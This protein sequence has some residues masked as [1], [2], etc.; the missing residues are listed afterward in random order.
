MAYKNQNY[1]TN[2]K[3][4]ELVDKNQKG[5]VEENEPNTEE[6][7]NSNTNNNENTNQENNENPNTNQENNENPNPNQ[8]PQDSNEE[9]IDVQVKITDIDTLNQVG[10]GSFTCTI[11][12]KTETFTAS[13]DTFVAEIE[14]IS[15]GNKII[16]ISVDN[17]V[18]L[19]YDF[20]VATD[21]NILSITENDFVTDYGNEMT[22][23]MSTKFT[24]KICI[25][26]SDDSPVA[27]KGFKLENNSTGEKTDAFISDENGC[28]TIPNIDGGT[29][30]LR[31]ND[32]KSISISDGQI[33]ITYKRPNANIH[34]GNYPVEQSEL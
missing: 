25:K 9:L 23:I 18:D 31:T 3:I 1:M 33:T 27:N 15:A 28:I 24:A 12:G 4:K 19:D 13:D 14:Q 5:Y 16:T 2:R 11:D 34:I 10:A 6:N 8:E 26:Y 7:N 29:Y 22:K 17:I 30:G 32:D 20:N 21:N